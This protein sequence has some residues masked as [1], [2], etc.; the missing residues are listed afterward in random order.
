[1]KF[2]EI[3]SIPNLLCY[4]RFLL[5]GWF[6]KCYFDEEYVQSAWIIALGGFT[7]FL[8]GQIARRCHMITDLGKI[9]DPLADKAMQLAIVV[10]LLCRY[11]LIVY[12]LILFIVK[13][14][15]QGICCILAYRKGKKL[16]GALW[17][18]KIATATFYLLA[19]LLLAVVDLPLWMANLGIMIVMGTLMFAFIMYGITFYHLV[20]E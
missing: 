20:Q 16:N 15:F 6:L 3:F 10:A 12:L 17:F 18:G 13:E 9:I 8:D 1:M 2:K 19:V 14:S 5:I 4:V 7:D 11:H